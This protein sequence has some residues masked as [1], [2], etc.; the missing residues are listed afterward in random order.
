MCGL[1]GLF[2]PRSVMTPVA[3]LP[4]MLAAI[5]HR[6]P[7]GVGT[8]TSPDRRYACGFAR[9]AIIDLATG[10]QPI[11][12]GNGERVLMG[13]GE[14]YNYLEL[15]EECAGYPWRTRGD[16]EVVLPLASRLGGDFVHR[17]NGMYGLA[18]YEAEPHR[19]TLVRDRLGIKPVY[20][21]R[22]AAG[23]ILFASEIKALFASGLIR[24][25]IDEGAVA[26]YLAHGWVPAPATLWKGVSKLPP[27]HRLVADCNGNV[28]IYRYWRARP[29]AAVPA[30]GAEACGILTALLDDSVRLQL[31]S[32][33]PV[34]ALLSGGIDSGLLVALAAR[35]LDRPLNTYTVRFE[36]AAVDESPLAALVAERYGTR[37][38][39]FDLSMA[40]V[41]DQ[42]PRL[43]WF[44]DE[45]LA[46]ASLLPNQLIEAVLGRE[47]RVALNGTGGDELFAGYGR[48]FRLPVE[49]RYLGLPGW[50]R[51]RLVEP[52]VGLIDPMTRWRLARAE[53]FDT[54]RGGYLH[55]H[56]TFFPPPI[57]ALLNCPLPPVAAAQSGHFRDFQGPADSGALYAELNTYLPEDL[58]LLLDRTSM[59]ASVEGRVPFLDHRLVE[60]ALAVPPHIRSPGG[61]QK[62]LERAMA[63]PFL[64]ADLLNAPKQGFASPVPAW[65]RGRLGLLAERLLTSPAALARGWWSAEG[66]RMLR[67]DPG[68]HG[69]RLYALMMLELVIRIH[70]E[71]ASSDQ[72]LEAVAG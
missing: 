31:R 12:E 62:A 30:D 67:S 8:W 22:T 4:A 25:E 49:R 21:A 45:P 72:G 29:A 9:L 19:L 10:D 47:V 3:D 23:A 17:L 14:I 56:C 42:M 16:M 50:A 54:D 33:V 46:D 57:K 13:N 15:R 59:A 58:L 32:D 18:L 5:R 71:G 7:D 27:G 20:W 51:R 28:T 24:P 61:R 1:A 53:K 37:H 68:C 41:A 70:A 35:R 43:A 69:H 63:A 64:P 44:C 66:I 52:L 38:T 48:Y 6:G 11:V 60:A 26:Q 34:G 39:L 2:V 65:M 55:D 36:G 40:D